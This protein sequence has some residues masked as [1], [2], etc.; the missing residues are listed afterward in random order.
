MEKNNKDLEVNTFIKTKGNLL[1]DKFIFKKEYYEYI[2]VD[3]Y[4]VYCNLV[5]FNKYNHFTE[6]SIIICIDKIMSKILD[7]NQ[8]IY[9]V[10]KE[11]FELSI[12]KL[13]EIS[14]K[15]SNLIYIIVKDNY[16]IRSNN[17]ERDDYT[18][19][20]LQMILQ[21]K[22]IKTIII[23]NDMYSNSTDI[24]N[25][26][27]PITLY[28]YSKGKETVLPINSKTINIYKKDFEN[29]YS[30]IRC[31]FKY[32]TIKKLKVFKK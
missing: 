32:Q 21:Q 24:I 25:N 18:C 23:S 20:L 15:Y 22:N 30:I 28:I 2:I 16:Y 8:T 4:N 13:L 19:L 27:K 1:C 10:S 9:I 31:G 11:I 3:F 17:K 5:K 14:N 26:I 7:K 12:D 29:K 6:E